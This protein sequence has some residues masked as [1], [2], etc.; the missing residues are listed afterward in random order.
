MTSSSSRAQGRM[1]PSDHCSKFRQ[2][3][4]INMLEADAPSPALAA[5]N[6][7][8]SSNQYSSA[9]SIKLSSGSQI[10]A[11]AGVAAA[12]AMSPF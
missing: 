9:F 11:A 6:Q 8:T 12:V 2:K 1:V 4:A 3:L 5:P 10:F 7:T